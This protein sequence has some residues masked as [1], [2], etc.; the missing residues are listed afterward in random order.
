MEKSIQLIGRL[1]GVYLENLNNQQTKVFLSV[2][3]SQTYF[4][5]TKKKEKIIWWEYYHLP[6][7]TIIAINHK[8][9]YITHSEKFVTFKIPALNLDIPHF[10][11]FPES[12]VYIGFDIDKAC[13]L[14]KSACKKYEKY[15]HIAENGNEEFR[16]LRILIIEN[17]ADM[18]NA[19]K[20]IS[21]QYVR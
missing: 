6:K 16:P 21:I 11:L 1:K 20:Y 3:F 12:R 2:S 18:I 5:P 7:R 8:R 10:S 4:R 15:T 17:E 13:R 9:F 14:D 19:I